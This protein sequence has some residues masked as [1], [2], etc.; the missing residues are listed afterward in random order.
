MQPVLALAFLVASVALGTVT[1]A[2]LRPEELPEPLRPWVPWVLHGAEERDCPFVFNAH[3]SR[4]CTW[5]T[6]LDLSVTDRGAEFTQWWKV[7]KESWVALPGGTEHWPEEVRLDGQPAVLMARKGR[8]EVRVPAGVHRISGSLAWERFPDALAVPPETALIQLRVDNA[9]LPH[10]TLQADGRLWLRERQAVPES[11]ERHLALQVFRRLV[12]EI[13][14]Q[15]VTRLELD[16]TGLDREEWLSGALLPGFI[17]LSLESPLPAR[18]EPDGRLRVQLRPGR[19]TLELTGRSGGDTTHVALPP[20]PEPWPGVEVWSFEA[21]NHLRLVEVEGVPA[22]DPRQT[23]LPESWHGLP[24]FRLAAGDTLGLKVI[25]RGDP[26]PAP[27]QLNVS[28]HLWLD[29]DGWGYTVRDHI[30]GNV[31]RAWRIETGPRLDLGRAAVDGVPQFITTREGAKGSGVEVRRGA[32]DLSADSRYEGGHSELPAVGWDH[33]VRT[34]SATLNLPPGWR[35]FAA[36][37][38]DDVTQSWLQ[39]W[40]LLDLFL[41]LIATLAIGRLWGRAA[42]VLGL[43]TLVLLWHEPDAPKIVWLN[44]IAATAL[45]GALPEGRFKRLMQGY[46]ILTLA[47]LA[48]ICVPFAVDQ[49]RLGLYPQLERASAVTAERD[50]SETETAPDVRVDEAR[51]ARAPSDVD[52]QAYEEIAVPA[53]EPQAVVRSEAPTI[54]PLARREATPAMALDEIDPEARVQTGPGLPEWR[55]S[56]VSLRWQGPVESDQNLRL[57]LLSPSMNLVLNLA[58]VL[59]VAALAVRLARLP[60]T[61][62]FGQPRGAHA[63]VILTILAL[64]APHSEVHADFPEQDLLKE[65]RTRLLKPPACLPS[66][67]QLSRMSLEITPAALRLR[68]LV[69]AAE[70]VAIPL[71]GQ[72]EQWLPQEVLLDDGPAGGLSRDPSGGLWLSIEPGHHELLLSGPAPAQRQAQLPLPLRPHR[73]DLRVEGWRVEGVRENGVPETHLQ[74]TRTGSVGEAS[75]IAPGT[76]PGLMRLTRTLRL[77]LDWRVE[78]VIERL[79]PPGVPLSAAVPLLDGESITTADLR[80][81]DGKVL[82]S[83]PPDQTALRWESL[84]EERGELRLRAAETITWVEVWR[85]DVSPIWHLTFNGLAPVH[86]QD[87]GGRWLPEWRPWPGEGLILTATRPRGVPGASLTIRRSRLSMRIGD[88]SSE[89]RLTLE[90]ES[91]R[92]GQHTLRLPEEARLEEVRIEGRVQPVRQSGAQVTLPLSPGRQRFDLLWREARGIG[93]LFRSS[94]I[95]LGSPSVNHAL[96]ISFGNDRWLLLAGGPTLGPAVLFWGVIAVIALGAFGLGRVSLTPLKGRHWFLLGVG[97]SQ[98]PVWGALTVVGWLLALGLRRRRMRPDLQA[99]R[100]DAVQLSLALLSLIALMLLFDAI[101]RG[102]LGLPEMQVAG[103]GSSAYSLNW[104][105]DRTASEPPRAWLISVPLLV[106]RM[107]MLAWALWL[108]TALLGWLRWGWESLTIGGLWRPLRTPK[109]T[110]APPTGEGLPSPTPR[111]TPPGM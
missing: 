75:A 48:L 89:A 88:R 22:V 106:Y 72:A 67:A 74:L 105:Q 91:S 60:G 81:R 109:A 78:T 95:D 99:L 55:W 49:V 15:L 52:R 58:R 32:L 25:R 7:Y 96:S 14:I 65:L 70:A 40:S 21:R 61:P 3:P 1:A 17:P 90:M 6:R 82:V 47:A 102:L 43:S 103:N 33:G 107:L 101:Q 45:L 2:T 13:P 29:M 73:V 53:A 36:G 37:G 35:L 31:T 4:R 86:H 98:A 46:R 54:K 108:A 56:E 110:P 12:D 68:L 42:A 83:L 20:Q 94:R 104:Y 28:R 97:L 59:L 77:G 24:A 26:D 92:G 111:P 44:L 8:P 100:F 18:L 93:T 39:S 85:V 51:V 66:C 10:P 19:W 63:L 30:T 5:P 38:S 27:D 23:R 11:S 34:L 84:L 71:P 87:P 79:S 69:H 50:W 57:W 64:L 80:V 9:L 76:L 41:V 16:V 62:L